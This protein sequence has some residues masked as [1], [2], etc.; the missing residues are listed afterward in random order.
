MNEL[1]DEYVR[2]VFES[3]GLLCAKFGRREQYPELES[4]IF[5]DSH[6]AK[7]GVIAKA[8]ALMNRLDSTSVFAN[9]PED[10]A[11]FLREALRQI[12][13]RGG[14]V[15]N[16]M[17]VGFAPFLDNNHLFGRIAELQR[18][19]QYQPLDTLADLVNYRTRLSLLS[20]QFDHMIKNYLE[21]IRRKITLNK[22]G[23]NLMIQL[24][25][26]LSGENENDKNSAARNSVFNRQIQAATLSG[27]TD[28]LVPV[29]RDSVL[30]GIKRVKDFLQNIYIHHCRQTDGIFGLANSKYEYE[31]LIYEYMESQLSA[32]EVHEIG[33][34]EVAR[35]TELLVK[36]KN[37]CGFIGT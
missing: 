27:N 31:N 35:I 33:L 22:V 3:N 30:P 5:D 15:P 23:T 16:D 13:D 18:M 12:I 9:F 37:S 20:T 7:A 2:I 24:C 19:F 17:P 6:D 1:N 34:K 8:V 28:F 21:G 4:R 29:L 36:A 26:D 11:E 25:H 14:L 32:D 10:D